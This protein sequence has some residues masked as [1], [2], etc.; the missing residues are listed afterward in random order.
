ME[1]VLWFSCMPFPLWLLHRYPK[2]YSA[3]VDRMRDLV[4]STQLRQQQQQ[5]KASR[6]VS[7]ASGLRRG[8]IFMGATFNFIFIDGGNRHHFE[9]MQDDSACCLE[10]QCSDQALGCAWMENLSWGFWCFS[11]SEYESKLSF[12]YT[13]SRL[14]P[15]GNQSPDDQAAHNNEYGLLGTLFGPLVTFFLGPE[16]GFRWVVPL[17]WI[18]CG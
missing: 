3:L 9:I 10:I 15:T 6:L 18:V 17:E 5:F 16:F 8:N 14:V 2:D 11:H 12:K 4:S 13:D 1:L 7:S